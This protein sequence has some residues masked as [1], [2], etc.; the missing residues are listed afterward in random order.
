MRGF[1]EQTVPCPEQRVDRR[2]AGGGGARL[3]R[4]R[5]KIEHDA[6]EERLFIC[7]R[8]MLPRQ[9]LAC[10]IVPFRVLVDLLDH[11]AALVMGPQIFTQVSVLTIFK[12]NL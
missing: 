12:M 3:A 8:E 6:H 9:L 7:V 10:P 2:G 1:V 4:V 5:P 11:V